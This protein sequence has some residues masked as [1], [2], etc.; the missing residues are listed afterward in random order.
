MT[1]Y[2]RCRREYQHSTNMLN[3]L[4]CFFPNYTL[5]A[6]VLKRKWKIIMSQ[7]K[8]TMSTYFTKVSL[9]LSARL[10]WWRET[11]LAL[12]L[13]R[14]WRSAFLYDRAERPLWPIQQSANA[15]TGQK[16]ASTAHR[17]PAETFRP[18]QAQIIINFTDVFPESSFFE[19]WYWLWDRMHYW[20]GLL[21]EKHLLRI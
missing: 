13:V 19:M 9:S 16:E 20:T 3:S 5:L 2:S 12:R 1:S 15:G 7:W 21:T 17:Q 18:D 8:T 11:W 14:L 10:E 6:P 4:K